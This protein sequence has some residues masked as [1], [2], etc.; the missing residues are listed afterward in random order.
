MDEAEKVDG[1]SVVA[2]GEAAEVLE[3]AEAPFDSV[4]VFAADGVVRDG[5]LASASGRDPRFGAH[6][7]DCAAR[8]ALLS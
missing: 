4:A 5:N 2:C 7:S 8:K 3:L 6:A 1:A